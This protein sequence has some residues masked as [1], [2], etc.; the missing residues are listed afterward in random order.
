MPTS[1]LD[2]TRFGLVACGALLAALTGCGQEAAPPELPP[3]AIQWQRV[4]AAAGGEQ[5]VISG[6]VTAISD[7][8]LAFEVGG[9]VDLVEVDLGDRVVTGQRLARLDPEP[10][11]LT[12][13]DARPSRH[14]LKFTGRQHFAVSH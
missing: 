12:V 1:R 6:I 3:R 5:R 2:H 4:S 7:T 14:A 8:T 9:T 11:E 10:L 13:R